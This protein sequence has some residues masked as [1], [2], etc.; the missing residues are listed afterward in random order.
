MARLALAGLTVRS[1]AE[2]AVA[3]GHLP[4]ALD[5]FGD[6]DTLACAER[7]IDIGAAN[8]LRIDGQRLLAALSI[9]ADTGELL[10]WIAASGFED[11]PELLAAGAA[12]LP[13]IGAAA[14]DV[15]RVRDPAG[16]F[17]FLDAHGVAHPPVCFAA[18]A[19]GPGVWLR[20]SAGGCG[21]LHIRRFES[22]AALGPGE[23]LQC[24]IEGVPMSATFVA[25]GRDAVLFGFNRLLVRPMGERPHVYCGAIG[26]VALAA[27]LRQQLQRLLRAASAGFGLRGLGSLDFLLDPGGCLQVLELN[28]R[29]SATLALYPDARPVDCHL[30]ACLHGE[31]PLA[32]AAPPCFSPSFSP[33]S[34][35]FLSPSAPPPVRGI[36]TVHA[37]RDW[38][39]DTA[40]ARWLS[41]Q[42]AVHDLP[43]AGQQFAAG[44]PVCSISACGATA[45]EVEADLRNHRH[46][47]LT[48]LEKS[49]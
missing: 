23:Y 46:A 38:T 42:S 32:P 5:C 1:L 40:R 16:F 41:D 27:P 29:P 39:L 45:A 21:G 20:K 11:Q 9:L 19:A 36:E 33:P 14:S 12:L 37:G 31:L 13:L 44:D 47:L 28:A 2:R 3:D 8:G 49:S 7:W 18:A 25:N 22:G 26:P 4:L 24:E 17:D 10:G 34:P 6:A 15:A 48:H 35:P 43:R 30:R